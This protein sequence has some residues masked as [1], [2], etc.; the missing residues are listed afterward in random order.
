MLERKWIRVGKKSINRA[1]LLTF[2]HFKAMSCSVR[3][4]KVFLNL[5]AN[6]SKPQQLD[7]IDIASPS[8]LRSLAEF[9]H[10][11]WLEYFPLKEKE[12]DS[13]LINRKRLE[14]FIDP[15]TSYGQK[16]KLLVKFEGALLFALT[17]ILKRF[18]DE[19]IDDD[20]E[21]L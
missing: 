21:C 13:I 3:N 16:K 2:I 1:A 20:D 15:S 17:P 10:C 6:T 11:V 4:N 7:L 12:K 9:A 14:V 8:Q 19:L 5:L 18:L